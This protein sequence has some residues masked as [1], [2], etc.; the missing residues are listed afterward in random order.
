[1]VKTP[2]K[3][4]N[5]GSPKENPKNYEE[6]SENT[7]ERSKYVSVKIGKTG[8]PKKISAP[9]KK[10]KGTIPDKKDPTQSGYVK[11]ESSDK[12]TP[13]IP[14]PESPGDI[15]VLK[16]DTMRPVPT[17]QMPIPI[18]PKKPNYV[19]IHEIKNRYNNKS[20]KIPS[21]ILPKGDIVYK[22]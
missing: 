22:R 13:T 20:M 21:P 3:K 7:E 4:A 17:S 1:M 16:P 12:T 8:R 5:S 9:P 18:P 11:D 19:A 2:K 15:Q 10:K 6:S 14:K